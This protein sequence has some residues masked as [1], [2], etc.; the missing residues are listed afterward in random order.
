MSRPLCRREITPGCRHLVTQRD[1]SGIIARCGMA[2]SRILSHSAM[3]ENDG[4]TPTTPTPMLS[5]LR[6][7]LKRLHSPLE[8]ML[9]CARLYAAYP[10]SLRH[11]EEMMQDRGVF[12][13]HS[14]VHRWSL[15]IL[16]ILALILRRCKRPVGASWRL[17][18]SVSRTQVK[19]W[20]AVLKMGVGLPKSACRSGLQ[21][22]RCC[23]V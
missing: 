8:V 15:K 18:E 13:D 5:E 21:I 6:K 23:C 11:R 9:V 3:P 12:V 10:L 1:V 7:V 4:M 14:K 20:D 22:A 19:A 2:A 16:P 17:D